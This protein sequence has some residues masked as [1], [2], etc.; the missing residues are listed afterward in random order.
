MVAISTD[1]AARPINVMGATKFLAE[2]LVLNATKDYS[3]G[4]LFSCVRFG[5]VAASRG[6]VIPLFVDNLLKQQPLVVTDLEVTRFI[7]RIPDAVE[8]VLKAAQ[9]AKG[10]EI[11]I[12]K[13]RAF[14]LKDLVD[15]MRTRIAPRLKIKTEN[16]ITQ[17]TGLTQGEKIHEVLIGDANEAMRTIELEDMY[18]VSRQT[19]PVEHR[20]QESPLKYD[21]SNVERLSCDEL[22]HIVIEYIKNQLSLKV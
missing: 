20:N 15:V 3:K 16:V 1:K 12:L 18:V 17:I 2:S 5:N 19:N 4:Q 22:E 7:I 10:G 6:S 11:F 8:L 13:M 14:L 9:Q 21:S